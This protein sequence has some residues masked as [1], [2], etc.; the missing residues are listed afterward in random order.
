MGAVERT[1]LIVDDDPDV[2][3]ILSTLVAACA[4]DAT[5]LTAADGA[6][7]LDRMKTTPAALVLTDCQMPRLGGLELIRRLRAEYPKTRVILASGTLTPEE[8]AAS[9]ADA[10]VPKPFD[11]TLV[12]TLVMNMLGGA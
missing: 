3:E 6:E 4:P 10:A 8:R 12:Q 2:R 1:V 5:V 7:A 9:G 11:V